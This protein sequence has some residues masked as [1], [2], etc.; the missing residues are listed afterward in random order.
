[1]IVSIGE[2]VWDIFPQ[3]CVLG[4]APVNVAYHLRSLGMEVAVVTRVGSD[5][6]AGETLLQLGALG[7]PLAG[8]QRDPGLPTGRVNISIG[9]DNEPSFDI[10]A[11]AAWDAIAIEPAQALLGHAPFSLVFGS[12]A[13]RDERSRRTI[14]SLWPQA[15]ARFYDVNLRPP[16]T[17][18]ELVLES[19]AV[20]D[21]VKM[22]GDELALVGGWAGVGG[23]DKKM[24]AQRLL[25]KY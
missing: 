5:P 17:T 1:M 6:L 21:L 9:D 12:L 8:V 7:L 13:Q 16:F 2:V 23:D 15:A 24:V 18:P 4:G 25:K 3:R 14:R 10:V 11:P 20:A 22:N 19:L